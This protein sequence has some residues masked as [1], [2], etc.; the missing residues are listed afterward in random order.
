MPE[1]LKDKVQRKRGRQSL[2][3][4]DIIF[5]AETLVGYG[6][7]ETQI[8]NV[9]RVSE[10]T[11]NRW[12]KKHPEFGNA[13]SRGSDIA[14]AQVASAMF[15]AAIGGCVVCIKKIYD[16]DG[17]LK[18]TEETIAPPNVI[19]GRFWLVNRAANAWKSDNA[20]VLNNNNSIINKVG[21]GGNGFF[22]GED[23]DF[24]GRILGVLSQ[25]LSK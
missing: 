16:K 9:F 22:S 21:S 5:Q 8:A 18:S 15:R 7:S 19:A 4:A 11:L 1:T 25:K 10:A 3:T 20:P 2:F 12:K 23:R 24:S 13:I 14:N 17:K 6:M